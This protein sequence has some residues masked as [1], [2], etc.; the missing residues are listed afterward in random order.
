MTAPQD[1]RFW[2]EMANEM[3]RSLH[4]HSL[5]EEEA[6]AE[7]DSAE[8]LPL[9]EAEIEAAVRLATS[10]LPVEPSAAERAM[11]SGK[12]EKIDHEVGEVIG[13]YRNE[14]DIDP[15]VEERLRGIREEALG[16]GADEEQDGEADKQP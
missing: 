1:E 12:D 4:L 15:E 5:S 2:N 9:S 8:D 14:G 10:H 3:R 11:S 7:Y 16:D 6:Q 13:M